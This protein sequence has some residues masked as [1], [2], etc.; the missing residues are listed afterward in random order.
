MDKGS[1]SG[2]VIFPDPDPRDTKRPD[3]KGSGT[4][5]G[6]VTL[7]LILF[8]TSANKKNW[9]FDEIYNYLLVYLVCG[10]QGTSWSIARTS[11]GVHLRGVRFI[12]GSSLLLLMPPTPGT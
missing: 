2:S 9:I 7:V 8:K 10:S 5:S 6:S 12:T 11:V 1:G 3:S 4:G